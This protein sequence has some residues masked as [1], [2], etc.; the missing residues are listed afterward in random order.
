MGALG[1]HLSIGLAGLTLAASAH[2]QLAAPP[3]ES[4]LPPGLT[5]P[6][7]GINPAKTQV[8]IGCGASLLPCRPGSSFAAGTPP[9]NLRWSVELGTLNLASARSTFG[10]RQ[11]LNLSLVGRQPVSL[12]GSNFS[13]YGKLGTTY[14]MTESAG[15]APALAAPYEAGTGLSF[16]AGLSMD[17]TPRLSATVGFDSYE[18]RFGGPT[19]DLVRSTNLGLQFKY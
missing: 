5:R 7:L 15:A 1:R 4:S 12:F 14:G 16:G 9:G 2:A 6:A 18:T 19:R 13:V 3:T 11:G 17:L 8:A 10:S